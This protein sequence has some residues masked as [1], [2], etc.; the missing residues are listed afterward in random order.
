MRKRVVLIESEKRVRDGGS[1][2]VSPLRNA[3]LRSSLKSKSKVCREK[4]PLLIFEKVQ[5]EQ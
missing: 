5:F 3:L 2:T 1:L 4:K